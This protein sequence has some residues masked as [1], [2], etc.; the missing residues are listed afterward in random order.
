MKKHLIVGAAL[1]TLIGTPALAADMALKAAP[2][3]PA[4]VWSWTGFYLGGNAGGSWSRSDVDTN[5]AGGTYLVLCGPTCAPAV[6]N[7]ASPGFRTNA[8]IGGVQAGYNYQMNNMV[9]GIETDFDSFHNR[10]SATATQAYPGFPTVMFT[11]QS[12]VSTDWLWTFR[13]RVG[14]ATQSF[15][16]YATGGVAVTNL[17][18]SENFTDNNTAPVFA[19]ESASVSQTRAGWTVG[20]G[21]EAKLSTNWSVKAEYLY[22]NFGSV[23]ATGTLTTLSPFVG[24]EV[25]SHTANLHTNIARVGLNYLF[26]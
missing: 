10:A 16:V 24:G 2:A 26:H 20:G 13:P 1:A 17:K 7:A 23:S 4:P 6:G 3:P 5:V 18:Y 15:L 8:F 19:R 11:T 21:A 12:N 9:L 25:F 22:A 14:V